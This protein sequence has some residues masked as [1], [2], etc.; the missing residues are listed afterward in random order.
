MEYN[1]LLNIIKGLEFNV[2]TIVFEENGVEIF[3]IRPS[4]AFKNYDIKKNFQ[5]FIKEG[6]RQFR[7]NHLRVMIDLH[8]KVRS[9]P[10]LKNELL[11]AFD[12][13]FYK[14]NSLLSIKNL[15][16]QDF[17]HYLNSISIIAVLSQLFIIEQDYNYEGESN[18]D[19][20]TLFYQG[21]VRQFI[22]SSKEIDNLAMSVCSRKPPTAKYTSLENK[23]HKKFRD[24]NTS[25][26]YLE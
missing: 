9:R 21:W 10:N 26:W 25:L 6:D 24:E 5:I 2:P 8:L 3:L 11:S 18:Y 7:P 17:E 14:G 12:N 19:P 16:E 20:P 15:I 13:I 22:D 23:K 4:K 1:D